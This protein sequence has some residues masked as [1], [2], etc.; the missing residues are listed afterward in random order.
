MF[1]LVELERQPSPYIIPNNSA[2]AFVISIVNQLKSFLFSSKTLELGKKEC[3]AKLRKRISS[4]DEGLNLAVLHVLFSKFY[5]RY[6][7]INLTHECP[8]LR[9]MSSGLLFPKLFK[10]PVFTL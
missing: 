10:T 9:R 4:I 2:N 3:L 7:F 5:I 6:S 1:L 8:V